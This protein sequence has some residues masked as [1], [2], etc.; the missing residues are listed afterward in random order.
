MMVRDDSRVVMFDRNGSSGNVFF[1]MGMAS[2]CLRSDGHGDDVYEMIRRVT[3]SGS[4][5]EALA[6]IGEYVHL[7]EVK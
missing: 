6:I 3:A 4:Y 5:D 1:I 2:N 7:V